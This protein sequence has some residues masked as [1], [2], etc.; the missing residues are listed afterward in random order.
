[1]SAIEAA[2]PN[3]A[4]KKSLARAKAEAG[5][6]DA[7]IQALVPLQETYDGAL[8]ARDALLPGWTLALRRLKKTADA[9]W[10]D[11]PAKYK[12]AFAAPLKI[13][14]PKKVRTKKKT[15]KNG[16]PATAAQPNA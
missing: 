15:K 13:A 10:V 14:A 8:S 1:M 11:Q 12:K 6:T 16:V 2:G 4:V 5:K 7:A 9:V 3:A